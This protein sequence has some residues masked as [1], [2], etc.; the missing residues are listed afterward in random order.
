MAENGGPLEPHGVED[1]L[2][3]LE[4][5]VAWLTAEIAARRSAATSA[6]APT[7]PA[8]G[9]TGPWVPPTQSARPAPP[10]LPA[11][12]ARYAPGA[13]ETAKAQVRPPALAASS[14]AVPVPDRP[15]AP[16]PPPPGP[17]WSFA[18]LEERLTGRLLAYVGGVAVLLGAILFLSLAFT[19]GWI[20]PGGRVAIGLV[21]ATVVFGLGAWLFETRPQQGLVATVLVGV[22]LGV[23]TVS[24][25]GATR[26]YDL[27]PVDVGL[28]GSLVLGIAAAVLAI[29]IDSRTVGAFGLLAVLGAPPLLGATPGAVAFALIG[30]TLV[31]T[32]IIALLRS[33]RWFPGLAFVLSAPQLASWIV[34]DAPVETGLVALA[35]F[36]LIQAIAAGGEELVRPTDRLRDTSATLIV[37]DAAFL[38]WGGFV[39]L[40]GPAEHWRALFLVAVALAHGVLAAACIVRQG[41]RHPFGLLVAGTGLAALTMAVPLQ[42]EGSPVAIAWVAEATVLAWLAAKRDHLRAG[43]ASAVLGA[44]AAAHFVLVEYPVVNIGR[45][46]VAGTAFVDQGGMTLAFMLGGI[47]LSA[48]FLRDIRIRVTLAVVALL[49]VTYAAPFELSG[50]ALVGGWSILGIVAVAAERSGLVPPWPDD[51]ALAKAAGDGIEEPSAGA[52]AA[53]LL[54]LVLAATHVA[55]IEL[56]FPDIG[57]VARPAIPFSD[58]GAL[59]A[60]ILVAAI[61]VMGALA[62]RWGTRLGVLVAAAVV[63]YA[64]PFEVPI[65]W[66]VVGWATLAVGG[67]LAARVDPPALGLGLGAGVAL[68]ALGGFVALVF[69]APPDRLVLSAPLAVA[70]IGPIEAYLAVVAISGALVAGSIWGSLRSLRPWPLIVAGGI[71]VYIVSVAIDDLFASR[72]GGSTATE[73]LAKQAQVSMSVAWTLIGTITFA[74]ALVRRIGPARQC[75]LALLALATGKVFLLDLASLDVAYR[76]LSLVGLGLLL[77]GSAYAYQRL[78]PSRAVSP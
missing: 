31:G 73:E 7:P 42:F 74:V 71:L 53:G 25:V 19:R 51:P 4:A 43:I 35:G 30:T 29:R 40:D 12:W 52:G 34:R 32:T 38:I 48:W 68:T 44:L 9:A 15:Q 20:D 26:L 76:V 39:L 65:A 46:H 36:W 10:P 69:L 33:W 8:S 59:G 27:I 13:Q 77:L 47:A 5:Q 75:G 37:A 2:A 58:T 62:G 1:R 63:A 49:L 60:T 16:P 72:V 22:G 11:G 78:R 67:Y 21:A 41:D 64:L 45:A 28:V 50:L 66:A 17:A 24:I 61:L 54:P 3:S 70:P 18:D 55:L 14:T 56:P 6:T 23:G 57:H